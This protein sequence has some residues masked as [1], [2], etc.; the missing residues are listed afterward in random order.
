MCERERARESERERERGGGWGGG[1]REKQRESRVWGLGVGQDQVGGGEL[2]RVI[3]ARV[4]DHCW[5]PEH[6]PNWQ[7]RASAG[8]GRGPCP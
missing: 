1:R 8:C 4:L 2:L 6:P 5:V 3:E 7:D